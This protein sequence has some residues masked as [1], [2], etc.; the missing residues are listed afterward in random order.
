MWHFILT[1]FVV[2][3]E[4]V[5]VVQFVESGCWAGLSHCLCYWTESNHRSCSPHVGGKMDIVKSKPTVIYLLL[6][7]AINSVLN[8]TL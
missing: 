8:K 2:V 6:H 1:F 4:G 7:Y 5:L 3:A